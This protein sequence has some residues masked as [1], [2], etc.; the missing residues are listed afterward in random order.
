[1]VAIDLGA[2]PVKGRAEA[3]L[4][5][6]VNSVG[7]IASPDPAPAPLALIAAAVVAGSR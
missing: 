5:Y 3:V 7:A 2:V 6:Q 4:C 1:V